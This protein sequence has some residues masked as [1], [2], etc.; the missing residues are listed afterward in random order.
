MIGGFE[1]KEIFFSTLLN[2]LIVQDTALQ[3]F[4]LPALNER[5]FAL[6]RGVR[7]IKGRGAWFCK[8]VCFFSPRQTF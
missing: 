3:H 1:R 8:D 5:I 7:L 4:E 6:A 2:L